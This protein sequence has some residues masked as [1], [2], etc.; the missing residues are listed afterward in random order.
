MKKEERKLLLKVYLQGYNNSFD[1]DITMKK[2]INKAYELGW[3]HAIVRSSI[4]CDEEILDKIY[5]NG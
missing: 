1:D 2:L 4:P 5:L 3:I